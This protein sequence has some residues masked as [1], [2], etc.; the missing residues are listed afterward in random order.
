MASF[1]KSASVNLNSPD[2]NLNQDG[3]THT[4]E[5]NKQAYCLSSQAPY[6]FL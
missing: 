6:H 5:N 2:C 1:K 4:N 3:A